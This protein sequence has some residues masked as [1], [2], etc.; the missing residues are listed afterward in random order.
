MPNKKMPSGLKILLAATASLVA[1]YFLLAHVFHLPQYQ[2]S[3]GIGRDLPSNFEEANK[4]F[5]NRVQKAF[6]TETSN[7]IIKRELSRQ[8]FRLELEK[9]GKWYA[10]FTKPG[11]PCETDWIVSWRSRVDG[12]AEE[13]TAHYQQAC[14]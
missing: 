8:G 10:V 7:G 1:T 9:D 5:L 14:L 11:F 12:V 2:S 6:P 3:P 13:M 4:E